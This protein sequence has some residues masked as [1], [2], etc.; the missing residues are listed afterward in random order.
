MA[1]RPPSLERLAAAI[2]CRALSSFLGEDN[3]GLKLLTAD[4]MKEPRQAAG[5]IRHSCQG[6]FR[7]LGHSC[8]GYFRVWAP[9]GAHA[10]AHSAAAA[11]AA[12]AGLL[13]ALLG[14]GRRGVLVVHPP[15]LHLPPTTA[16]QSARV[17]HGLGCLAACI[18]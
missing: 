4:A 1:M 15:H 17:D 10:G 18:E 3:A 2:Q 11:A 14:P 7:V 5:G 9:A 13:E 8:Q 6:Y 16:T 12:E